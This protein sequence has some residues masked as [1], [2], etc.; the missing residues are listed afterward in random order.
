MRWL[1]TSVLAVFLSYSA[2]AQ[3]Y[4]IQTFAG[5]ALPSNIAGPSASLGFVSAVAVDSSG[6]VFMALS[7]YNA[8]L[9]WSAQKHVVT[10]VAGDGTPGFSGDNGPATGAQ[11]NAPQGITVDSHGNLYIADYGNNRIRKVVLSTG[12]IT[13][14]A[15]TGTGGYSGDSGPPASAELNGPSGVALDSNLNLYI[16]DTLNNRVRAV[17]NGIIGTV[18]GAGTPGYSGDTGA[19][20]SAELHGPLSVALDTFNNLY[21]ADTGNHVIREVTPNTP[22][23]SGG[24]ITTVAGNGTSGFSGD[25][26]PATSAQLF[27][28]GGIALDS[29]GH[30]Y[31]ADTHNNRIRI[32]SNGV[33]TTFAGDGIQGFGGDNGPAAVAELMGP[34]GVAVDHSGDLFIADT[35]NARIREVSKGVITTFAGGGGA[36]GDDGPPTGAQMESPNGVAVDSAGNVYVA[37]SGNYR[38]REISNNVIATVA[39]DG[40]LGSSGDN[41]PATSAEVG[42]PLDIT[43][44]AAGNLYI[45]CIDGTVRRVSSGVIAGVIESGVLNSPFGIAVDASG[46]LYIA[47]TDNQ[48][49]REFSNGVLATVAGNG[50]GGFSGDNGP[51]VG[52]QLFQ[53]QGVALDAAGN[54]YIADSGN[55][56]IRKVTNGVITTVAGGGPVLGD[57]LAATNARLNYPAGMALDAAG[58]LYIADQGDLRVR[59]V[60][61]GVIST[62]AGVGTPGFSG[63]GGAATG[64]QFDSPSSVAV[65]HS[66]N[67]YVADNGNNRVRV[68]IPSGPACAY[69][70][71]PLA[72][73]ADASG[74]RLPV[75]IQTTAGCTWEVS[76]LP[77]WITVF[78]NSLGTGPTTVTLVVGANQGAPRSATITIAGLSV[79]VDQEPGGAGFPSINN[80]GVVNA[81]GYEA[82]VAPGSIAAVFGA[83][84]LTQTLIDTSS[85]LLDT[86]LELS[87]QFGNGS[88]APLFFVSGLQVNLQVPWELAAASQTTLTATLGGQSSGAVN[89]GL[90]QFAPGIFTQNS[91]G[92]GQGSITDVSNHLVDASNPATAGV[93]ILQIFCTGLGPVNNP[94]ASGSP[95]S[96][97]SLSSTPAKATVTIGG[98]QATNVPFSGLAPGYVGLYQ[99]NAQVPAGVA[100]GNAVP[101][102]ISMGGVASNTVT[103]AVN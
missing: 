26:G 66:G 5:G 49:V 94:P 96:L 76:E 88:P 64:A 42:F 6:N 46:N 86:M 25:N 55:H 11:L 23:P 101:V 47:D 65:D 80:G 50:K 31:I 1:C 36:L 16:A 10:P 91:R 59:R 90:A 44:D 97:T 54:L 78:S 9:E 21:I 17:A 3:T 30:L 28:P 52:A 69:T 74:G 84:L 32:V 67:L 99:V 20:I 48:V 60:S 27:L 57:G 85:P 82:A 35:G 95:A 98:I 39:G 4:T 45:V 15:G 100:S 81:A 87:L 41:G 70:V 56:R 68:L 51:A 73:M 102:V 77:Q 13:T 62:I 53:P 92:T 29:S 58:N 24:I 33:I 37:D 103:I 72:L 40:T 2:F 7:G 12:V 22:L 71:S 38:I 93:T 19:A 89:V 18:A 75:T 34:Q 63:D 79:S 61:G 8:V 43:V 14:V 83:F